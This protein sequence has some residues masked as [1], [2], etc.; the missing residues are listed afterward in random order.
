MK[1]SKTIT[2]REFQHQFADLSGKL[3]PGHSITVTKHGRPLGVFTKVGKIRRAP[4]YLGNLEKLAYSA[5]AG[6]KLIDD[7]CD[8]S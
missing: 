6:Q 7:I 4:D 8:L 5:Q 2:C 3:K 1:T